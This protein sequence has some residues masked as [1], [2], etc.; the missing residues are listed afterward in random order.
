MFT[1]QALKIFTLPNGAVMAVGSTFED[2][3]SLGQ[4]LCRDGFAKDVTAR[5]VDTIEERVEDLEAIAVDHEA[6][7]VYLEASRSSSSASSSSSSSVSSS[8]SSSSSSS[9]SSSASAS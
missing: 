6:R 2:A 5:I 4:K 8:S 7:I 1:Y 9:A 3:G